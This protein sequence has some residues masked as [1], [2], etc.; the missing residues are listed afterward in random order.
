MKKKKRTK[1]FLILVFLVGI[2]T[3]ISFIKVKING[4]EIDKN[5]IVSTTNDNAI[6]E[7]N[8]EEN[9]DQTDVIFVEN[10]SDVARGKD[11]DCSNCYT[12]DI[13]RTGNHY[14]IDEN[15][16]LWGTGP[17]DCG[18]L[19]ELR[20]DLSWITEPKEIAH[21]VKHVDFSGEY[22]MI[23]LTN[24][25][26]LYGLGG[27]PAGILQES[28]REN[29]NRTYMHDMNVI[30]EPVL[31]MEDV[32]FAKCGYSTII[33]LKDNGDVYVMGNNYYTAFFE[34]SY[35]EPEKVMENAKYVTSYFHTFAVI[36]N[37]NS[38]WTW[39][40]NR[41]G[42]CGIG[43]FSENEEKP[44]KVMDDVDCAWMGKVAFNSGN[45]ISELDNLIVLKKDGSYYGCGIGV[46]TEMMH[47]RTDDFDE[48]HLYMTKKV[49]AS[50]A[51]QEIT[52]QEYEKVLLKPVELFWSE[53]DLI[54]FL[55]NNNI[56]YSVE[57]TEDTNL[58]I[59]LANE[60]K[61]EFIFN[62]EKELAM[63]A[64][65]VSDEFEKDILAV[66]DPL[67]KVEEEYGDDY[68]KYE[69]E[70]DYFTIQYDMDGYDFQI[71][72]YSNLG[73][74]KFSKCMKGFKY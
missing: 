39:G 28:G 4:K 15:G 51:F 2:V 70:Y 61:W 5:A 63:I 23:F 38:L 60:N 68:E 22:F 48:E 74:A 10:M 17:S 49:A 3:V 72:I 1:L 50:Y 71:G 52:I 35:Y 47:N 30:T 11:L 41:M 62:A 53:D 18:Q 29:F 57:Y 46:D 56:D 14:W 64:S 54:Q 43:S 12:T 19:G 66:G 65:T 32:V 69:G 7:E 37:D 73:C 33:A 21:N 27:N 9:S 44:Q 36:C 8:Y 40:D 16:T 6:L 31:L 13:K 55:N 20:D 24:D 67:Q 58:L 25:N 45:E 59:Y 42:Q 26:E 34:E